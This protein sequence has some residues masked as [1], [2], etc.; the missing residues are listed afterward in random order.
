M[1]NL[2]S[3]PELNLVRQLG[4]CCGKENTNDAYIKHI[5]N[6]LRQYSYPYMTPLFVNLAPTMY[7]NALPLSKAQERSLKRNS[8]KKSKSKK[9]GKQKKATDPLVTLW[10]TCMGDDGE[11]T[12]GPSTPAPPYLPMWAIFAEDSSD[13][14]TKQAPTSLTGISNCDN[15]TPDMSPTSST[16]HSSY[17]PTVRAPRCSPTSPL[18]L[19]ST[20]TPQ[21]PIASHASQSP[22]DGTRQ[23]NTGVYAHTH[24]LHTPQFATLL[25]PR[26]HASL[27][28][29]THSDHH[30]KFHA[31]E[32]LH[33]PTDDTT[34]Q[35]VSSRARTRARTLQRAR[36]A[37]PPPALGLLP[38]A[39]LPTISASAACVQRNEAGAVAPC[40]AEVP[41]VA[42]RVPLS[43]DRQVAVPLAPPPAC[44]WALSEGYMWGVTQVRGIRDLYDIGEEQ[45]VD[46]VAE[47]KN[48]G[49]GVLQGS[50]GAI[51]EETDSEAENG[52]E[53]ATEDRKFIRNSS[54]SLSRSEAGHSG[55]VTDA[56]GVLL[57]AGGQGRV[58][59]ARCKVTGRAVAVKVLLSGDSDW[60]GDNDGNGG[61]DGHRQHRSEACSLLP[62]HRT[63]DLIPSHH[64]KELPLRLWRQLCLQQS[65]RSRA[66]SDV[67]AGAGVLPVCECLWDGRHAYVVMP[68]CEVREGTVHCSFVCLLFVRSLV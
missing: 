55:P 49:D 29:F 23:L 25:S 62:S 65:V 30:G 52:T 34:A 15:N 14:E 21:P 51:K 47:G 12:A 5:E 39:L 33:K 43:M 48:C 54:P 64:A 1:G 24:Q 26:S 45:P 31:A 7:P 60:H 6:A 9:K 19:K 40:V 38:H 42:G 50:C 17:S 10:D 63:E 66:G 59:R 36:A 27:E 68:L 44:A 57:G 11:R 37:T 3:S 28:T 32:R 8:S 67:G 20:A 18:L 16:T 13:D 41:S 58:L 2:V 46:A 61:G 53:E 4:F 35:T 22:V 56:P